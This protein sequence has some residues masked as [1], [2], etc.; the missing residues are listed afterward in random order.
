MLVSDDDE[1]A[2][3]SKGRPLGPSPGAQSPERG[4]SVY[5]L[6]YRFVGYS[7]PK[8]LG[9]LCGL[10]DGLRKRVPT[11]SGLPHAMQDDG[12]FASHGDDGA[13]LAALASGCSQLQTP[14]AQLRVWSEAPQ[15]V[16]RCLHQQASEVDVAGLGYAMLRVRVSGLALA[17]TQTEKSAR[18]ATVADLVLAVQG[19][20]I[21]CGD[22]RPEPGHGAQP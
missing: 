8:R 11:A 22:H 5:S 18:L 4:F 20:H 14:A 1:V 13:L 10:M 7:F 19:E 17:R 15:H 6:A 16:L 12:Q 2:L 3:R 21:G 9:D